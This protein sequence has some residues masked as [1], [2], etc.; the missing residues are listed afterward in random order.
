[1]SVRLVD[2]P[3]HV[4]H[5]HATP[6]SWDGGSVCVDCL[7]H[8]LEQEDPVTALKFLRTILQSL[9]N[10]DAALCG[11]LGTAARTT[12]TRALLSVL[13]ASRDPEAKAL[14]CEILKHVCCGSDPPFAQ[15][16]FE[17]LLAALEQSAHTGTR[18]TE[19]ESAVTW[20]LSHFR[21]IDPAYCARCGV[22]VAAA[23]SAVLQHACGV[24]PSV[25]NLEPSLASLRMAIAVVKVT[26]GENV[27]AG[28]RDSL[29]EAAAR[30]ALAIAGA[31]SDADH[32]SA[33]RVHAEALAALSLFAPT[34]SLRK[35][36]ERIPDLVQITGGVRVTAPA[37]ESALAAAL[38]RLIRRGLMSQNGQEQLGAARLLFRVVEAASGRV[39]EALVAVWDAVEYTLDALRTAELRPT[40]AYCI[41]ALL[42]LAHAGDAFRSRLSCAQLL[43]CVE[44]VERA[45]DQ[46]LRADLFTLLGESC[47]AATGIS[48][49]AAVREQLLRA[50]VAGLPVAAPS[51]RRTDMA[52][53]DL[54]VALIACNILATLLQEAPHRA[55]APGGGLWAAVEAAVSGCSAVAAPTL[56]RGYLAA[57]L[58]VLFVALD[59]GVLDTPPRM[60]DTDIFGLLERHVVT[61]CSQVVTQ[62]QRD[63]ALVFKVADL[64]LRVLHDGP[65]SCGPDTGA[66]DGGGRA[67]PRRNALITAMV[68]HGWIGFAVAR[69]QS[70]Q[71]P[72]ASQAVWRLALSLAGAVLPPCGPAGT[73]APSPP[74]TVHEIR[75]AM[76]G[77]AQ[78]ASAVAAAT[79]LCCALAATG[80]TAALSRADIEA[81][82]RSALRRPDVPLPE[83]TVRVLVGCAAVWPAAQ[84]PAAELASFQ[85]VFLGGADDGTRRAVFEAL[86]GGVAASPGT[87]R[88]Q[89]ATNNHETTTALSTTV[90]WVFDVPALQDV[91]R[92]LLRYL[93]TLPHSRILP[94]TRALL[95]HH[96]AAKS[97]F[98]TIVAACAAAD[99]TVRGGGIAGASGWLV[100]PCHGDAWAFGQHG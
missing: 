52:G 92:H 57:S 72:E 55:Q 58:D 47:D 20:L 53:E 18:L 29:T 12:V 36:I 32:A 28:V 56:A 99:P 4:A 16:V 97:A 90:A 25:D 46:P 43:A 76:A 69:I 48:C 100:L 31:A 98:S 14:A 37:A 66:P 8:A 60:S 83:V 7:L 23:A 73:E 89:P 84:A 44:R 70:L 81:A 93:S 82:L 27:D 41:H 88:S 62:L 67:A 59:V 94:T 54:H 51:G 38:I 5:Q 39:L 40:G 9:E 33:A 61:A 65:D 17:G 15:G 87:S 68:A 35:Q 34:P 91:A 1:M 77:G 49:T 80:D 2:L 30:L 78:D 3:T 64:C 6:L 26:E 74:M 85:G 24:P 50:A 19:C 21:A 95:T 86:L 96:G 11:I 10:G 42:Q 22:A 79:L 75:Q 13:Q 71:M 63:E 45:G